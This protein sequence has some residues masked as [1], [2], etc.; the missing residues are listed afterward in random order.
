MCRKQGLLLWGRG[1]HGIPNTV[2]WRK[3]RT[4][5]PIFKAKQIGSKIPYF[6]HIY[7]YMLISFQKTEGARRI[8]T[9]IFAKDFLNTESMITR[10]C[11]GIRRRR[12]KKLFLLA[13]PILTAIFFSLHISNCTFHTVGEFCKYII[14]RQ[15]HK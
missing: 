13:A 9:R 7:K 1:I 12:D 15:N 6:R 2:S 3:C 10:N 4:G 5:S 14:D 8:S 11:I